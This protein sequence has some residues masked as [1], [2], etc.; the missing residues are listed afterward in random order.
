MNELNKKIF[1]LKPAI[2]CKGKKVKRVDFSS[3]ASSLTPSRHIHSSDHEIKERKE[4]TLNP[5]KN[6]RHHQPM[7]C[8]KERFFLVF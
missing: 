7:S 4:K 2:I 6:Y 5:I 8:V 3:H 1:A